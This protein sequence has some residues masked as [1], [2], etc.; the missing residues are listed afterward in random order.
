MKNNCTG[1]QGFMALKLDMSKTYDKVEW[2]FFEQIPLKLGFH[3][4]CVALLM[5]CITT[6]SYSILV[7]GEPK[8]LF[9]RSRGLRQENPLSPYLVLFCAK[10]L[11][12]IL[13]EAALKEEIQGFSICRNGPKLNHLFFPDDYLLFCKA[14]LLKCE[15]IQEL[16]EFYEEASG[17]MIN[18]GKT[19]LFL[20]RILIHKSWRI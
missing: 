20:A 13:R 9:R 18:K 1:K 15:K 6:V 4:D 17:Q 7:N 5:E 2:S 3:E 16:L 12:A 11:N 10:V 8:D 19:T 14:S